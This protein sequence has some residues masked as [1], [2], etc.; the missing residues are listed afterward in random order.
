MFD[1]MKRDKTNEVFIIHLC[2]LP[3]FECANTQAFPVGVRRDLVM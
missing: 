3:R 1:S 2:T